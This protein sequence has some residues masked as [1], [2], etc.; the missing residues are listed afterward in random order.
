MSGNHLSWILIP[1]LLIGCGRV[2]IDPRLPVRFQLATDL[3]EISS[4]EANQI[5][6]RLPMQMGLYYNSSATQVIKIVSDVSRRECNG[7]YAITSRSYEND[8]IRLC[9]LY[10][11][12]SRTF[13]Q[14]RRLYFFA[15]VV[16]HESIHSFNGGHNTCDGYNLMC[17]E[18]Y[19]GP[20]KAD[21]Y[22]K[23]DWRLLEYTIADKELICEA[24]SHRWVFC[25]DSSGML[26][27]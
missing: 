4:S 2:D 24:T 5:L 20:V 27:L 13:D 8:Q 23:L 1:S 12:S 14:R 19:N 9:S 10:F 3:K 18:T 25:T 11:D 6:T 15:L 26:G 21:S 7:T 22:Q 17:P 16:M